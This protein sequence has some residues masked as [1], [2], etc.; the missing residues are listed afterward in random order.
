MRW[1]EKKLRLEF[2][3]LWSV[4]GLDLKRMN[5]SG[6]WLSVLFAIFDTFN[7]DTSQW[8]FHGNGNIIRV[9]WKYIS[10]QQNIVLE[11]NLFPKKNTKTYR[12]GAPLP[13]CSVGFG[14]VRFPDPPYFQ[15]SQGTRLVSAEREN[16][17]RRCS[18]GV[19]RPLYS[20]EGPGW[21]QESLSG[22]ALTL[23]YAGPP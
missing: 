4:G 17:F 12:T 14:S 6:I 3:W 13:W 5:R 7:L 1:L 2:S 9:R 22:S 8:L 11:K 21:L 20:S 18:T 16:I 19:Q 15:V 23:Y 10:S